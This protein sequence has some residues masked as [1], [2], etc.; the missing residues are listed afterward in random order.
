MLTHT[1]MHLA[2]D[3]GLKLTGSIFSFLVVYKI[4][5]DHRLDSMKQYISDL[6][7]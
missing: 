1:K 2:L 4:T 7:Q 5:I 6:K 3:G